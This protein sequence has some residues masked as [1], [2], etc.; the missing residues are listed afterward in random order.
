MMLKPFALDHL[1][2]DGLFAVEPRRSLSILEGQVDLGQIAERHDAIAIDLDGQA[3]DVAGASEGGRDL[4]R[5]RAGI[6]LDFTGGDQQVVV[7]HHVDE[8]ICGDVVGLKAQRV[9]DDLDHLVSVARDPGLEHRF[10]TLETILKI[11]GQ[12]RHGAF[13]HVAAE[14]D[15]DDREFA[16]IDLVDRV[17]LSAFGKFGLGRVHRVAHIGHD[18]GLVPAELELERHAGI[19]LG[20]SAAHGL[21]PVEIAQ[22]G[23]HH[24]DQQF[25]AVLSG[26]A[27]EGHRDEES[28]NLD[29]GLAFLGQ[30]DIGKRARQNRKHDEGDHHAG[31]RGGPVDDAGHWP[32][33]S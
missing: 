22:F 28:R 4:D 19:V 17:F 30:A 31:S 24:L 26:D 18:L 23:L 32:N 3:I 1:Q 20:G 7:A 5:E 6:G 15:D 11:L 8:L 16:E 21:E 14:I 9:D 10:K 13:R 27:G 25:L 33:S 29:V 12:P 2:R